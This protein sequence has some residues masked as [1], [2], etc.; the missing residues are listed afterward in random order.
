MLLEPKDMKKITLSCEFLLPSEKEFEKYKIQ[1]NQY[2]NTC[3]IC[4]KFLVWKGLSPIYQV[5]YK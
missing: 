5:T 3:K 1:V 4:S 2:R